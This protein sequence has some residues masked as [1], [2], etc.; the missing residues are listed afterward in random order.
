Q[1]DRLRPT[2]CRAA[3]HE[4]MHLA[5]VTQSELLRNHAAHRHAD[6]MR[7]GKS[8]VLHERGGVVGQQGNA[9]LHV[10]LLAESGAALVEGQHSKLA[11]KCRREAR[12]HALVTL[13]AMDHDEWFA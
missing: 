7:Q 8:N 3:K 13:R 12:K 6:D 1:A 4:S 5:R 10:R 11:S 2:W 9:V